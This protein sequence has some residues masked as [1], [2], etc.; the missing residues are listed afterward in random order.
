MHQSFV[1][2]APPPH[3]WGWAG[4]SRVN[5]QGSDLLSC[6]VVPVKCPSLWYNVN[7]PRGIYY[8]KEQGYDSA[9]PRSVGQGYRKPIFLPVQ[10][11]F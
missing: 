8:Y 11:D 3:L 5:V 4:D 7:T 9:S 10:T 6:P 1:T 2:T